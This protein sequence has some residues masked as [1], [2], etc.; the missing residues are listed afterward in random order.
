[1]HVV[2]PPT[3]IGEVDQAVGKLR[4]R[5]HA[6]HFLL[7]GTIVD[8]TAQTI[9]AKEHPVAA[10]KLHEC[11][12]NGNLLSGAQR[13]QD[14]VG[15]LEGIGLGFGELPRFDQLIHE[16]L[17]FRDQAQSTVPHDVATA[18]ADLAHEEHLIHDARDCCGRSHP[19]TGSILLGGQE[20]PCAGFFDG[21]DETPSETV[22]VLG[23]VVTAQ[24]LEQGVNCHMAS[25]FPG[26]GTAHAITDR[27]AE[28]AVRDRARNHLLPGK[29]TR[30]RAQ[31]GDH[32]VVFVVLTDEPNVG[33]P[34]DGEVEALRGRRRGRPGRTTPALRAGR[35]R[36]RLAAFAGARL[37]ITIL[38]CVAAHSAPA[39]IH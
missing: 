6:G 13:L 7:N 10:P 39:C 29:R 36:Y 14:D 18:I 27:Q 16:R 1:V 2:V 37:I 11:Q 38:M 12:I 30:S 19:A 9:G 4:K 25:H 21:V 22:A 33:L 26:G 23:R 28:A 24:H 31:V 20:N 17:I 5:T 32:E 34:V 3:R 15:V 8:E 35:R